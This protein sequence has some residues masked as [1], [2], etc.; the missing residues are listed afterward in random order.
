MVWQITAKAPF[1][2]MV[3]RAWSCMGGT[4][5]MGGDLT[6]D[7]QEDMMSSGS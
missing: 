4:D 2:T 6:I 7:S 3:R 5:M 1:V